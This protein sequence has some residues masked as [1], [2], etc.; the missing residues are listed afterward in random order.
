MPH[1]SLLVVAVGWRG[2]SRITSPGRRAGAERGGVADAVPGVLLRPLAV[3]DGALDQPLRLGPRAIAPLQGR[4][5][6][7]APPRRGRRRPR[8]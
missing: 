2:S 7:R 1:H 6:N 5:G 4:T 8:W 3:G